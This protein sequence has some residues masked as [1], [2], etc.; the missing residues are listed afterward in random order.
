MVEV[1]TG[2]AVK[3]S[4]AAAIPVAGW[5]P[6]VTVPGRVIA[7]HEISKRMTNDSIDTCCFMGR[8][9]CRKYIRFEFSTDA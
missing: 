7:M 1:G 8:I 4:V 3:A 2:E 6:G 5:K 9:E